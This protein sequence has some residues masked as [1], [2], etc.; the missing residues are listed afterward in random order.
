MPLI[1]LSGYPS[2]GKTYRSL[3]LRNFFQD[4]ILTSNDPRVSRLT[5]HHI[6]DESLGLSRHVYHTARTE[7]DARAAEYSAVKRVLGRDVIVIAD[8]MNYI[9][10]FRYQLYC[11]A[12]ALQTPSCV[13]HIGISIDKC[14]DLHARRPPELRYSDEDFENLLFRY[15]EPNGMTRWDS[16][17]FIVPFEDD[18]PPLESIWEAIIGSDGKTK[19]IRQN[20]ATVLKP[21]APENYLYEMDHITSGILTRIQA[22]Q[23]DHPGEIGGSLNRQHSLDKARIKAIFV[24]YLND[25]FGRS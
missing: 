4:K 5:V 12:K 17:C 22:Y 10:G 16:P 20:P 25:Q 2:S 14:R 18:S 8:S 11:E 15:E 9:K 23:S 1:L 19:V 3:Q 24:E 13:V 7:K 21:A 6:N